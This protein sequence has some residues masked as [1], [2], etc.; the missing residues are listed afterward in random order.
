[1]NVDEYIIDH[2]YMKSERLYRFHM[3]TYE[4]FLENIRKIQANLEGDIEQLNISGEEVVF[5]LR[6]GRQY[7]LL[8]ENSNDMS[9]LKNGQN[10]NLESMI[11]K[12]IQKGNI[13]L[14]VG[15]C[16]GY[17]TVFLSNIVAENGKVLAFEPQ[18]KAFDIICRNIEINKCNNVT[19]Y[20]YALSNATGE[21]VIYSLPKNLFFSSLGRNFDEAYDTEECRT[22]RLDDFWDGSIDV[23]K[24]DIEG[25]ECLFLEG[26]EK[27]IEKY[28]PLIIMEVF[29][30]GLRAHKHT[31]DTIQEKLKEY[32]PYRVEND[33]L[34]KLKLDEN[35]ICE[36]VFWLKN[37]HQKNLN[38]YIICNEEMEG[39][40]ESI[41]D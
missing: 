2:Y 24:I 4:K 31:L 41:I 23:I 3:N 25:A 40:H 39:Y 22:Y 8:D 29:P 6:D 35:I 36:D 30:L 38:R 27:V 18:K 33:C 32:I 37:R 9:I 11:S 21:S 7:I 5:K 14:E 13:V 10:H 19:V 28:E 20:Q 34:V 15:A 17:Y 16:W 26:A 1:M 12:I